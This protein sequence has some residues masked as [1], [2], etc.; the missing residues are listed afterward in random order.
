MSLYEFWRQYIPPLGL[1]LCPIF[2][3]IQNVS[4]SEWEVEQKKAIHQAQSAEQCFIFRPYDII[5]PMILLVSVAD[6]DALLWD[7]CQDL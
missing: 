1:L 3:V 6:A 5:D 7:I 4:S 2:Q